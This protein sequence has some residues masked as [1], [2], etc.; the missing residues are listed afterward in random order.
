[1]RSMFDQS[2]EL[3]RFCETLLK[4]EQ[5]KLNKKFDNQQNG[6]K[7]GASEV[8]YY[9]S[10]DIDGIDKKIFDMLDVPRVTAA[11]CLYPTAG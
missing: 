9:T 6:Q 3:L 10:N 7:V 8:N 5:I 11:H 2:M 4:P 1:M